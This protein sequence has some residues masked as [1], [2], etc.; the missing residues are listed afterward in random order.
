MMRSGAGPITLRNLP[1]AVARGVRG[2]AEADGVSLNKAVIRLLEEALGLARSRR[3]RINRDFDEFI[4]A[5][6]EAEAR[7]MERL[8]SEQRRVDPELWR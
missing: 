1:P 6:T 7:E 8:L 4:G 3:P 5:W 2:R